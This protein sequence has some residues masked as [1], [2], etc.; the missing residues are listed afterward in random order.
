MAAFQGE[1]LPGQRAKQL[2]TEMRRVRGHFL[3]LLAQIITHA[4]FV[5]FSRHPRRRLPLDPWSSQGD[6]QPL[7]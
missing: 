5:L 4:V 7:S 1:L 3:P 6:L 2:V